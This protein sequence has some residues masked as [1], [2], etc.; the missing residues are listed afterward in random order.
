MKRFRSLP[1]LKWLKHLFV[2]FHFLLYSA[3]L[4][5]SAA[6]YIA[7]RP[8]SLDIVNTY[9]LEPFDIHYSRSEGSLLTGF[10]LHDVQNKKAKA[11]TL[12]LKYNL[13]KMLE[14]EHTIDSIR[15]DGL[16]LHLSD[17]LSDESSPW[18]FPTFKLREVTVTNLQL[19]STYPIELDIHAKNGSYD[20]DVLDFASF[21]AT[22]KS[23]YA[24]GAVHGKVSKN[25][26]VGVGDLY[27]NAVELAPYIGKFTTLPR[28]VRVKINELSDTKALLQTSIASLPSKQDALLNANT[29]AIDFRYRYDDDYF[30]I[31]ATYLLQR[32][33]DSMQT[34][35][36]LRYAL[37]GKTTTEFDGLIT[38]AHPLPSNTLHG[39]FADNTK[40]VNGT[41]T[42][43]GSTLHL[44]S[45]DY[46]RFVWELQS[47]HQNL[48]FI[49]SLPTFLSAS[50][51]NL[52]AKGDYLLSSDAIEG[53]ID[54][55][56]DSAIFSGKFSTQ[57][58]HH[59][60]KGNLTLPP[61]APLW[62]GWKH[63]PPEHLALYLSN[64]SNV[65]Q[66]N[67]SAD[68]LA[69]TATLHGESI[70]GS[71]NYIGAF[72]DFDGSLS[73]NQ[74]TLNID[75]LIPSA[76]ASLSKL[77]PI[78][79][80]HGEYYDMEVRAKTHVTLNNTLHIQSD[81]TIPWYAAVLD[82]QRSFGGTDGKI[83]V[84][85]N[86]GNITIPRYRLEV[87]GHDVM[88]DKT[89]HMHLGTD[90]KLSIDE[91]WIYDSLLLT[92]T[93]SPD[94]S[95]SLRLRSDRFSYHGPEGSAHAAADIT[96]ERDA[97]A[98][99][100]LAGSINILDATITY[101]PLQQL[102]VMD[103][104]IIII[105]DVR[106]PSQIKLAMNLHITAQQPIH[107]QTKEL[108]LRINPDITLWK[109]PIALM[110][111]L[112]MVSI[113]SG[114][115]KTSGKEFTIKPS[116]IYF[117]GDVPLNPY[118]NLTI[119]YEV[120]YKKILIYVTHTLDSPIFLFSSDP[121][122]TQNDIMSY[123]LFGT[124]AGTATGDNSSSGV[125]A[126]ATNFMLGA[127]IKGLINGATKIQIDTMNI[128]S[129]AEGG[130]GFEVGA[131]LNKDLRVLYKNDTL[132]SVLVQYQ[133]NRWL[134]L[135]A[136]IHALGQGINAVYI[137]DFRDFLPHNKPIK[138]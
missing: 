55:T 135:D 84:S 123:I 136:D 64:E 17:F 110:Q 56:H 81:I 86:D 40:G 75:T 63:K 60:L 87:A 77:D 111:I 3:V 57:N 101:L 6:F 118:L 13:V 67:L 106:P 96:F 127:G 83:S 125:R 7:F 58:G 116:E 43:D 132:S 18:P 112:G 76:F 48:N 42:L 122:M 16:Q 29:I 133:V 79:L 26:L 44:S 23:R 129:N 31:D 59:S 5:G 65:S 92:G 36:H 98:N 138:K 120:D 4:L 66:I 8:D 88:S 32:L 107:Y 80:S 10:T 104:D 78:E 20:G 108:D 24:S 68:N 45:H 49:P 115:A 97:Q 89:S 91:F 72:F 33:Q 30:D 99:Q 61:D 117:G 70:K 1:W 50:P 35:Q 124:P 130:M 15:I 134:R 103:D 9:F 25:A 14:G 2:T 114:T 41:M 47:E 119:A 34:K 82:S 12:I 94:L 121:V 11:K 126:D 28:V 73:A 62:K 27:P 131:K 53:F 46:E 38:S 93:V 109:D 69:L 105:Q 21:D 95:T 113:S 102:K 128:L 39:E 100:M 54:A 85:Y 74:T 22:L 71:G 37:E 137:K 19:I 51:L 52:K 90:G